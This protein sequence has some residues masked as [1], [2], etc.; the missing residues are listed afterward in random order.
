MTLPS[1][2]DP[3]VITLSDDEARRRRF[4]ARID[5][6]VG[7]LIVGLAFVLAFAWSDFVFAACDEGFSGMSRTMRVLIGAFIVTAYALTAIFLLALVL[8]RC[9]TL[10]TPVLTSKPVRRP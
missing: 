4:H 5:A 3:A 9:P 7:G 8:S 1:R 6:G 2:G 10:E